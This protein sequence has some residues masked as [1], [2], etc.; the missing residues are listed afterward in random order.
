MEARVAAKFIADQ[1]AI[2]V[3][4]LGTT[5]QLGRA[6]HQA[7]MVISKTVPPGSIPPGAEQA[8]LQKFQAAQRQ[9]AANIASMRQQGPPGA[10]GPQAGVQ[11]PPTPRPPQMPQ[12]IPGQ[13]PA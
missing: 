13:Q 5:S 11:T 7:S 4:R 9:N 1:L 8:M 12:G 2:L 6:L 10:G 3:A